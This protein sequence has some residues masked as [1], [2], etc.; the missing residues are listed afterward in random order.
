MKRRTVIITGVLAAILIGTPV[1]VVLSVFLG[2]PGYVRRTEGFREKMRQKADIAAI[3][4]WA[5]TY[6]PPAGAQETLSGAA[7]FV[8]KSDIPAC[9]ADLKPQQV[10]YSPEG[11]AVT[12]IYGGGFGHWGLV[13]APEGTEPVAFG[14]YCV[15]FVED[16]A[17]VWHEIQ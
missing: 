16:G 15:V 11:Q 9:I 7:V 3:R 17:W 14:D 1:A 10:R 13:V 5:E 2:P 4:A 12:L 8:P 6:E